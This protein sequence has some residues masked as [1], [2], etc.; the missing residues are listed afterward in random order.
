MELV[1]GETLREW[2]KASRAQPWREVLP[3]F[4]A[5]GRGLAAAHAAGLVHRDFKPDNVL[6]AQATAASRV[7]DFGLAR[8]RRATTHDAA[9]RARLRRS[10][11]ARSPLSEHADRWPARCSA[12]R[13][14]WRPSST[15]RRPPTRAAISSRSR[16]ALFEALFRARP[17][18]RAELA[19]PASRD[20]TRDPRRRGPRADPARRRCARSRGIATRATRAMA[21]LLGE[22]RVDLDA[23]KRTMF[24][25]LAL[26]A[27]RSPRSAACTACAARRARAVHG[28]GKR[29]AGAWDAP[30]AAPIET[31]F[32][33][34][35]KPFAVPAFAGVE[36]PRSTQY[37]RAWTAAVTESC[38]A[39]RVRGEQTEDVLSLRE[40]C[41]DHRLDEVR[42]L[43]GLLAQADAAMVEKGDKLVLDLDPLAACANVAALRAPGLPP[44]DLRPQIAELE[45][46]LAS[47]KAD[48]LAG[49]YFPSMTKARGV[50]AKATRSGYRHAR[51]GARRPGAA[52]LT[53]PTSRRR[54]RASAAA[55]LDAIRGKRDDLAA[56][57][58]LSMA[59][60]TASAGGKPGE[61]Q[62]WLDHATRCRAGSAS[63]ATSSFARSRSRA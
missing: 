42:A 56:R 32:A 9:R 39:T 61:A 63:I 44:P 51:R 22:L 54:A 57:A 53:R 47:A 40:A 15:R 23:R 34:T 33:A 11:E 41:L 8:L 45:K 30:I 27:S 17:Y 24:A 37:T 55:V 16:V 50:I 3:V 43:T 29:L 35:S 59:L 1:E 4:V 48:S 49:L 26:A 5:A 13:R 20:D 52:L 58:G 31:A 21:E 18:K 28:A 10:I 19:P 14:T 7:M 60:V 12:R 25:A 6:V 38:E 36:A 62:I 2:L 46:Q